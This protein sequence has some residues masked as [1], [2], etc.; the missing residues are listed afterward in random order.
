[1]LFDLEKLNQSNCEDSIGNIFLKFSPYL[2]SYSDYMNYMEHTIQLIKELQ[3]TDKKFRN[4]FEKLKIKYKQKM[5][6]YSA[7][8]L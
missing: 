4:F 2:K 3:L 6:S 1:M 8:L 7:F 5:N